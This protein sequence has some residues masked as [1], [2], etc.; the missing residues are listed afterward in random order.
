M[1]DASFNE[2]RPFWGKSLLMLVMTAIMAVP[3][4]AASNRLTQI[5]LRLFQPR[6]GG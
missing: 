4:S 2:G 3:F 6:H 1:T 5:T